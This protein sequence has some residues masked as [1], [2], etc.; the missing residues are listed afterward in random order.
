M[1]PGRLELGFRIRSRDSY[2]PEVPLS[3]RLTPLPRR[4]LHH[5]ADARGIKIRLLGGAWEFRAEGGGGG[6]FGGRVRFVAPWA[7][8]RTRARVGRWCLRRRVWRGGK[9]RVVCARPLSPQQ[10]LDFSQFS[11]RRMVV[12]QE[13]TAWRLGK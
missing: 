6:G 8:T 9:T 11:Q 7:G 5:S 2:A 10:L 3:T 1:L 12:V 4:V 13:E